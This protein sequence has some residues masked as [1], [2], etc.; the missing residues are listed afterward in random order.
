ML[1]IKFSVIV[2]LLAMVSSCASDLYNARS[3][4][5]YRE[6]FYAEHPNYQSRERMCRELGALVIPGCWVYWAFGESML[7]SEDF[8]SVL[9]GRLAEK[10]FG[11][12]VDPVGLAILPH[13]Y[14]IFRNSVFYKEQRVEG[15]SAASFSV[16][17]RGYGRTAQDVYCGTKIVG[18]ARGTCQPPQGA[19]GKSACQ[20]AG[21]Y[22][23]PLCWFSPADADERDLYVLREAIAEQ[24]ALSAGDEFRVLSYAYLSYRGVVYFV[25]YSSVFSD[26][27]PLPGADSKSFRE[28]DS[29]RNHTTQKKL[30]YWAYGADRQGVFCG[31]LP[32]PGAQPASFRI[33]NPEDEFAYHST[34]GQGIFYCDGT[35]VRRLPGGRPGSFQ[36]VAGSVIYGR[37]NGQVYY[38]G[39]A[40]PGADPATFRIVEQMDQDA[41]DAAHSY[42]LGER[43]EVPENAD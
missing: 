40:I 1:R 19:S 10:L 20:G 37:D 26:G 38:Q 32:L 5:E 17:G 18:V 23:N 31:R 15:A 35:S 2:I 27:G 43:V 16:D 14:S 22:W 9:L 3:Y 30:L 39:K 41:V 21:G 24:I 11:G 28:I 13:G 42:Y 34:D 7:S 33:F 4:E 8:Q 25:D 29:S 36:L 6:R 12:D